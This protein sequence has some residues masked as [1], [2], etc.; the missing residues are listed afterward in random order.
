[1]EETIFKEAVQQGIFAI[2]FIWLFMST[3]KEGKERED[4][5]M[6]HNDKMADQLEK[7]TITLQQIERSLNGLEAEMKDVRAK[8]REV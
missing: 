7:N 5:L 2:L 3:R 6:A 4:K 1:M 8:L